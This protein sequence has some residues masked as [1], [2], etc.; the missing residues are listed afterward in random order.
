MSQSTW[1]KMERGHIEDVSLATLRRAFGVFDARVDVSASWRGGAIDRLRDE[2]HS[3]VVAATVEFLEP[4]DWETAVEV[5]FSEYGE[6]GSIDI[7]AT[8]QKSR[9]ALIVEVKTE[10][11]SIEETLRRLD[12]KVRLAPIIVME[13]TGWRPSAIGRLLVLDATMT[14]RRRVAASATILDRAFPLRFDVAR[15]W[16]RTAGADGSALLFVSSSR[17]RSQRDSPSKRSV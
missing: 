16:L 13:R 15:R 3:A 7:L 17:G 11:T 6:R 4:L 14:N 8:R 9:F 10:L 5:T 1:S 12:A 2:R